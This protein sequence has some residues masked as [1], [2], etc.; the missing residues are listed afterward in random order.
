MIKTPVTDQGTTSRLS[1]HRP[2]RNLFFFGRFLPE[3]GK[4]W[5]L[6]KWTGERE[7]TGLDR[8]EGGHR[9]GNGRSGKPSSVTVAAATPP[10]YPGLPPAL[11]LLPSL[12]PSVLLSLP[13]SLSVLPSSLSPGRCPR[14]IS[15]PGGVDY[16]RV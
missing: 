5:M 16:V 15:Q 3:N 1:R 2:D 14:L 10:L 6:K 9:T 8:R 13:P 4:D 11:S 7:D 12:R